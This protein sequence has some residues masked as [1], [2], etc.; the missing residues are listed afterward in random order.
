M[1]GMSD[2]GHKTKA[3]QGGD[4]WEYKV[5]DTRGYHRLTLCQIMEA[6]GFEIGETVIARRLEDGKI[7]VEKKDA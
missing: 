2:A 4:T 5:S 3:Y 7:L 1:K 6:A